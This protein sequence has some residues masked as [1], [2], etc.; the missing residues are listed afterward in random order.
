M[1]LGYQCKYFPKSAI[2]RLSSPSFNQFFS[3]IYSSE[4]PKA[5]NVT[6]NVPITS[7]WHSGMSLHKYYLIEKP[8]NIAN[9]YRCN[10]SFSLRYC[11][12]PTNI[13]VK[14]I[15]RRIRGQT[16]DGQLIY[17]ADF[18]PAYYHIASTTTC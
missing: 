12:P 4:R 10:E 18:T 5:Q 7:S 9:C 13:I 3:Q 15:D 8:A 1:H 11:Q 14:H 2:I 16:Q 17:N 6:G